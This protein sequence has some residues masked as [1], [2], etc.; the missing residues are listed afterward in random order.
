MKFHVFDWPKG[1]SRPNVQQSAKPIVTLEASELPQVMDLLW[2]DGKPCQVV[3]R[4]HWVGGDEVKLSS[5][6]VRTINLTQAARE[7]RPA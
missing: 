4:D 3:A 7:P 1:T 2:I 6:C 5:I